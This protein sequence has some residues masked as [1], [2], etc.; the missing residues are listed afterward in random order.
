MRKIKNNTDG[1]IYGIAVFLGV[2]GLASF[3]VLLFG[4]ILEV[5]FCIMMVG[6]VRDFLLMIWPNGVLIVVF[7]VMAFATLMYYQKKNY[8]EG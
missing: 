8:M 4:E 7:I 6:P 3:L 5:F 2:L 1:S